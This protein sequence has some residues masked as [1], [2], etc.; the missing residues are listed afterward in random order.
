MTK[1]GR[2][3][4]VPGHKETS[5]LYA[6]R[7][8]HKNVHGDVVREPS[9][10]TCTAHVPW[11]RVHGF[12]LNRLR[13]RVAC[14]DQQDVLPTIRKLRLESVPRQFLHHQTFARRG[15]RLWPPPISSICGFAHRSARWTR[16]AHPTFIKP[17]SQAVESTRTA[18]ARELFRQAASRLVFH[19]FVVRG[20]AHGG[21][22]VAHC[23]GCADLVGVAFRGSRWPRR[24]VRSPPALQPRAARAPMIVWSPAPPPVQAERALFAARSFPSWLLLSFPASLLL[25]IVLTHQQSVERLQSAVDRRR[26]RISPCVWSARHVGTRCLHV[27]MQKAHG[28]RLLRPPIRRRNFD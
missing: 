21:P 5:R 10:K 11:R 28:L 16:S 15:A 19:P 7:E 8:S 13:R 24:R 22:A 2:E 20:V 3:I 9:I 18:I 6:S 12:H 14:P 25:T 26:S 17:H 1:L 4:T 27:T 23:D